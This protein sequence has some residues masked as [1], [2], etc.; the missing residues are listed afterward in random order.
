MHPR[1]SPCAT[2]DAEKAFYCHPER[3]KTRKGIAVDGFLLF[4][5]LAVYFVISYEQQK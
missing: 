5:L 4:A 3:Q 2:Q 1:K